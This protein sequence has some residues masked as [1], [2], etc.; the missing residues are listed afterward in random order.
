MNRHERGLEFKV[1]AFV[2]VGLAMVAALVVQFGRLGEGFKTYYGLT[3]RFNDAS[4]LLKGSDVLL[5][6]AKIGKVS[7]GPRL[8]REGNGVDVPLKIYDYVKV[9]EGS[10]FT[11][12]SSGLL[13]DRFVNVTMP[14]GQPKTY[15]SPNAYI[16]GARETGLDDLTREGGALVNDMRGAVQNING[17]FTRLNEDALSST[18]MQNLKASIEHLSQT[19][20]A[21]AQSSRKLDSVVDKADATMS[22]T[23]KAADDL[24]KVIRAATEGKGLLAALLTNQELANDLRAL[25]SNLRAHGVLFY[26]D[27]AAKIDMNA[28]EQPKP[29]QTG[30]RR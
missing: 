28:R 5:G 16:S 9:P 12:G 6:G 13:G 1:G 17:T 3:I 29:R 24:Q 25:I 21:L 8:V 19:T 2:F 30:G 26:R 7:G 11:V 23:K 18:N 27:S 4:G 22:S 20:D 10:K 14:A 15:L